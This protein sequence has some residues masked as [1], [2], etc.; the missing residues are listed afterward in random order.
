MFCYVITFVCYTANTDVYNVCACILILAAYNIKLG[1]LLEIW[2]DHWIFHLNFM[3]NETTTTKSF[4]QNSDVSLSLYL[5]SSNIVHVVF[6]LIVFDSADNGWPP[7]CVRRLL[8]FLQCYSLHWTFLIKNP[9]LETYLIIISYSVV[10]AVFSL[11]R[12]IRIF[13]YLW[14]LC[15]CVYMANVCKQLKFRLGDIHLHGIM[16]MNDSNIFNHFYLH[17]RK[18]NKMK[19]Y[20]D[21]EL[22]LKM[23]IEPVTIRRK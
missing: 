6:Y 19:R 2:F 14:P 9:K 18:K 7:R 16:A 8:V 23:M 17:A 4:K 21:S 10:V 11:G 20:S 15:R 1:F 5:N 12:F 3:E 22:Q 13:I